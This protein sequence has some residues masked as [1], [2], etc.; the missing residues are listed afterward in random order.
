MRGRPIYS[1]GA[2]GEMLTPTGALLLGELAAGFGPLP[3]MHL[4][5]V[6]Y[7]AG[8]RDFSR[9]NVLRLLVGAADAA[10]SGG[11][12]PELAATAAA[13]GIEHD[14]AVLLESNI[15]D[16]N[17]QL[18]AH[19]SDRL[20]AAGALDVTL[21]A[22]QMKK[23]RPGALLSVLVPAERVDAAARLLFAETTTIGLRVQ[24]VGRL[25]LARAI[26]TVHTRYGSIGVKVSRM[27]AAPASVTPEYEDCRRAALAHG[28][29]LKDVI[30]AARTAWRERS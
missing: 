25:K 26:E 16:M 8:Q 18:Y 24:Q 30:E 14:R 13:L 23:G 20:F 12:G 28:A 1:S 6:G 2:E 11:S 29:P 22:I 9:P 5:R 17:P 19:V 4:E 21:A 27:G 15:D 7:G 3:L 10:P